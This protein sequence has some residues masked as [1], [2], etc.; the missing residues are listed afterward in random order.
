MTLR[1]RGYIG[2]AKGFDFY[3][4]LPK[5]E[6]SGKAL[7]VQKKLRMT[8]D[9]RDL[10]NNSE[11]SKSIKM[12][13]MIIMKR[14]DFH[15][16]DVELHEA[17]HLFYYT[18]DHG[19]WQRVYAFFRKS[20]P[21]YAKQDDWRLVDGNAVFCGRGPVGKMEAFANLFKYY[22]QGKLVFGNKGFGDVM[23]MIL[24]VNP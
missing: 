13:N 10:G 11:S 17:G 12:G 5:Y 18:T 22:F 14:G 15:D 6:P 2:E 7:S 19:A 9:W 24:K 23:K 16:E 1:R 21:R 3:Q 8:I 20:T 4:S